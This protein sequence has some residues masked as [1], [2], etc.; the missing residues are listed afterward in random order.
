MPVT[1]INVRSIIV[2]LIFVL[3]L[4]LF[5]FSWDKWKISGKEIISMII[6]KRIFFYQFDKDNKGTTL[7][8][9]INQ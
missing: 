4:L 9:F 7:A 2:V 3:I 8:R 5:R 1:E 6:Y